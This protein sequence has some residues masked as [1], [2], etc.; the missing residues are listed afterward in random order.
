MKNMITF[1]IESLIDEYSSYV[2]KIV[3]QCVGD[4]LNY[5][6]KEEIVADTF[7]LV[8][9]N[10]RKIKTNLKS[11]LGVVARNCSYNYLRKNKMTYDLKEEMQYKDDNFLQMLMIKQKL[12]KLTKEEQT[13]FELFY[14]YGYKIK[15]IAK[16]LE[17]NTSSVKIR[18]YRLRKKLKE[19]ENEY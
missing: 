1:N 6:D 13:I 9:K 18:L 4:S 15:E 16:M 3:H 19:E 7:F 14:T 17:L 12:E 11:Y 2:F 10:Q 5:Q 8:W